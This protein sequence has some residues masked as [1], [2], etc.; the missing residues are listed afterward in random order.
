MLQIARRLCNYFSLMADTETREKIVECKP[1]TIRSRDGL[2]RYARNEFSQGGEDGIL[3]KIFTILDESLVKTSGKHEKPDIQRCCVD[4]GAWDGKHL[5]NT[6]MLLNSS[7]LLSDWTGVLI[8]AD[9]DRC[10]S[11]SSFIV[12]DRLIQS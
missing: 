3:E 12:I 4:V 11:L 9:V 1:R 8:E 10:R 2:I 7:R 5:S 6:H